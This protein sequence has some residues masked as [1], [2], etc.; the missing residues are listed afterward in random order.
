ML[1]KVFL[2]PGVNYSL[3]TPKT[4]LRLESGNGD[5]T[6]ERVEKTEHELISDMLQKKL[7]AIEQNTLKAS[8]ISTDEM[9]DYL[10]KV[11]SI[12]RT[13]YTDPNSHSSGDLLCHG[14]TKVEGKLYK[15]TYTHSYK[16]KETFYR[17][18]DI[19]IVN[20]EYKERIS[21][22]VLAKCPARLLFIDF[23]S[24]YDSETA[25]PTF[26]L[27]TI[28]ILIALQFID[29]SDKVVVD[30][31]AGS[32]I[33]GIVAALQGAKKVVVLESQE[34]YRD[35]ILA[36]AGRNNC[37][38]KLDF[39][40]FGLYFDALKDKQ[41]IGPADI[42]L[43][44]IPF[45]GLPNAREEFDKDEVVNLISVFK[46]KTYIAAGDKIEAFRWYAE[47]LGKERFGHS[48]EETIH[49]YFKL[50]G[51]EILSLIEPKD[52][53]NQSHPTIIAVKHTPDQTNRPADKNL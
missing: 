29:I 15:Y 34:H 38:D 27:G 4:T 12:D 44:N 20:S 39:T 16:S 26:K 48:P 35:K 9:E 24:V 37:L 6:L 14:E 33:I 41:E 31:G 32:G 51:Y 22:D 10:V 28:G 19:F 43:S 47:C 8:K 23:P 25:E 3:S 36:N 50:Y 18:G 11:F 52:I 45:F 13:Y 2:F 7:G 46:P 30:A 49:L 40:Y 53:I 42:V 1:I 5:D 17:A 21:K